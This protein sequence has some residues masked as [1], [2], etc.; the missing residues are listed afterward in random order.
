MNSSVSFMTAI[1]SHNAVQ[2]N[3]PYMT[4]HVIISGGKFFA[5]EKQFF[6]KRILT[7]AG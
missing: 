5:E 2:P 3:G 1:L 6:N 4:S 7:L